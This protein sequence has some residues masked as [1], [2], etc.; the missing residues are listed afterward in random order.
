VRILIEIGHPAQIHLFKNLAWRLEKDGHTVKIAISIKEIA[1]DLIKGYGFDYSI[2]YNNVNCGILGKL[3]L[4]VNGEMEMYRLVKR[5]DPDILI[6]TTSE[7]AGPISRIFGKAHIGITDT[8][9]ADLTNF[10][11]YPNTDIILTPESF[12][13]DLGKKH[14]RFAGCKELAYL[15][16]NYFKPDPSVL[17]DLGL[18]E[19]D[20]IF[21]LR[22]AAFNATHDTRS[23]KFD[24]RYMPLLIEKLIKKGEVIISS[25]VELD[26][27]LKKYQR[28]I[29]PMKYH[30]LLYYSKLYIGEG[31]TSAN[32][33]AI[34][35]VPA[36]HFERLMYRAGPRSVTSII[37]IMDELQNKYGLVYSFYDE[38]ELLRKADEILADIGASKRDWA[39]KR[40]IFLKDKIDVT[41]F[42]VWF[43]ENYPG[44]L[45]EIKQSPQLQYNFK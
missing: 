24:A 37:G 9:H 21:L 32:E 12:K 45:A 19:G 22:F 27:G 20:N 16:P 15:H 26:P 35:G 31:S 18:T 8:E 42:L 2:L 1:L 30:H 34:L 23:E 39:R 3:V 13:K 4:L 17:A 40:E 41:A 28:R 11:A 33:A 25:E 6:S 5:F 29:D 44:S 10:I 36:L 14:I 38:T 43:I 7:I